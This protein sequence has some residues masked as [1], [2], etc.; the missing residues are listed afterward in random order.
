ME[1]Y[2]KSLQYLERALKVTPG[3]AQTL[4]KRAGRFPEGAYPT[5]LRSGDGAF[6]IDLDGHKYLDMICGLACTTL[7]YGRKEI[8]DAVIDQLARGVSFSLA[9]ELESEVAEKICGMIPCAEMVRFVKT[10]SEANEAAI[11]VARKATGKDQ[12]LTIAEGYHS[13]HSWFQALKP[14]HPGIPCGYGTPG[15]AEFYAD[16][17]IVDTFKFNDIPSLLRC[18]G[19]GPDGPY[20]EDGPSD[21]P[22][23][24]DVAAIILEPCHYEQP[25]PGFLQGVRDIATRIGAV[26]IFDEMVSGFRWANGG[27]Q[28]YYGVTPDLATFGKACANGFPLAFLCGRRDLME[29]ADVISGTFGGETLSLAACNAVLDIYQTEPIIETLWA[30]GKQFKDG[31]NDLA[32]VID[33]PAVCD[34]FAVKPRIKFL[35][36]DGIDNI[37]HLNTMAMSLF[38]QETALR[39]ILWHPAGGNI[40]AAMTTEDID[41]AVTAMGEALVVVKK[42]LGSGDWIALHGEPIQST[43]FVRR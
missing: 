14:E 1:R 9:T 27:A 21:C 23:D 16:P 20:E 7:G 3:G 11:R 42:A 35:C 30:R 10:G 31:L 19:D 12:V 28:A 18:L 39:G 24:Y 5:G 6:V 41:M 26:L 4:S 13:W 8:R 36:E 17:R 40:S 2:K 32:H 34:G 25:T 33:V 43:P 22:D 15:W 37:G 29:H 38:L